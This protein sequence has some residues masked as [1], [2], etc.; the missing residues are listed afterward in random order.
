MSCRPRSK[1]GPVLR[2]L[3]G[4]LLILGATW[5]R[6]EGGTLL[7]GNDAK[8]RI[9]NP[10]EHLS[11]VPYTVLILDRDSR[12][13]IH[14]A[15][16]DAVIFNTEGGKFLKKRTDDRDQIVLL[17]VAAGLPGVTV[18]E[19]TLPEYLSL[20]EDNHMIPF[21]FQ[22]DFGKELAVIYTDPYNICYAYETPNGIRIHV[23]HSPTRVYRSLE[24]K[25]LRIRKL[26]E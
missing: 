1:P 13:P 6:C 11:K 16:V 26:F 17:D 5:G 24:D 23:K 18:T 10:K 20:I 12:N 15:P 14:L 25:P 21:V 7:I 3:F 22:D 2:I 9:G 8:G 19:E 4:A